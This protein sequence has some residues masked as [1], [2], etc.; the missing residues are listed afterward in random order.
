MTPLRSLKRSSICSSAENLLTLRQVKRDPVQ[1]MR[2]LMLGGSVASLLAL[3]GAARK[4]DANRFDAVLRRGEHQR[5][6]APLG[7]PGVHVRPVVEQDRHD[8]SI[9]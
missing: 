4:Q 9:P 7:L 2:R 1:G 3:S 5:R 8:I 6:L